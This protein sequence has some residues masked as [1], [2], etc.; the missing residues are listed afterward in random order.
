MRHFPR[1][2]VL[3]ATGQIGRIL[4]ICWPGTVN[5]LWQTRQACS[6][7]DKCAQWV[8]FDPLEDPRSLERAAADC[9]VL[10]CLSGVTH[11]RCQTDP[12][13]DMGDNTRLALAA[14]R[15]AAARPVPA[16]VLLASSA[17]VYG[18]QP[19]L[20]SEAA[21]LYPVNAYGAAKAEMEARG[22]ELG[23]ELGVQVCSLR[24]GNIAGV[25]AILGGWRPGFRL[26]RFADG[27]SPRRSYIGVATLARV[28]G[29]LPGLPDLPGVLNIAEPGLVEMAALL[30]AAGLA[31]QAQPAPETAI[32][33]VELDVTSLQALCPWLPGR[34]EAARL[35]EEW[36]R[37]QE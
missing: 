34:G 12:Q 4:Q 25:D 35:V 10:L 8:R 17:A 5:A 1:V 28:L 30:D 9:D 26:D 32:P 18:N 23:A 14:I 7:P 13:A 11:K 29:E 3:G 36:R 37:L 22:A 21:P 27:R 15:A 31:W 16:R 24:I 33:E 6:D 20:L 19:G 2:L